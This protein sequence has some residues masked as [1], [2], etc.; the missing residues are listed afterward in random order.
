MIT[1][2][3]IKK[4]KHTN[5]KFLQRLEMGSLMTTSK[6]MTIEFSQKSQP[7]LSLYISPG[8][9]NI[10]PLSLPPWRSNAQNPPSLYNTSLIGQKLDIKNLKT[11]KHTHTQNPSPTMDKLSPSISLSLSQNAGQLRVIRVKIQYIFHNNY[12]YV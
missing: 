1:E 9:I 6:S 2:R 7:F 11:K 4:S 8:Q 10:K 12:I 3:I 5:K